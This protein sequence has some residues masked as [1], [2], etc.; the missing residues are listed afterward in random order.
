MRYQSQSSGAIPTPTLHFRR[1]E[2]REIDP[3]IKKYHYSH[4][5]PGGADFSFA[6][7]WGGKLS[8]AILFGY[9]AGNPRG[10]QVFN[11][12]SDPAS[13]RE[14]MRLVL[15]D[16]VPFNSESRFIGWA[17]R[18]LRDNTELLGL[19]SFADPYHQH[20]GGVYRATNWIYTGLQKP[21]RPRMIINGIDVH[22]RMLLDRYGTSSKPKLEALGLQVVLQPREPKHRYVYVLHPEYGLT[23]RYQTHARPRQT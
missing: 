22:P 4:T 15:L 2:L 11:E 5:R 8:G 17:L 19:V 9:M 12:I 14:L 20:T 23:L 1:T 16:E 3:F 13:Y 18:W 6:L 7:D 10:M 21:D